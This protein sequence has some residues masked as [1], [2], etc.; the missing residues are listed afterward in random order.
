MVLL[1]LWN[2]LNSTTDSKLQEEKVN[3]Y[4]ERASELWDALMGLEMQLVDQLEVQNK[5]KCLIK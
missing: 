1:Q 3:E 4:N 2:L 5:N